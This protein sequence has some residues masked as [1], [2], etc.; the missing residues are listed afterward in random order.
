MADIRQIRVAGV[1]VGI[2]GLDQILKR[3]AGESIDSDEGIAGR[4]L[5]LV[6]QAN[7]VPPSKEQEYKQ[8]LLREF[9]R[10]R[11]EPV[12]EETGGLEVRVLGPGC[13]RCDKLTNDVVTVLADLK[14]N[15]DLEHVRDL[16]QI[17][18]FGPV[19]TPALVINGRVVTSGRVPRRADLIRFLKEATE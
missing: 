9:K 13:A 2:A 12:P 18:A 4:L 1:K 5:G 17:A 8:A 15:A 14:I 6:R 16:E 7:Y 3:V 19:A 11:G 10:Y